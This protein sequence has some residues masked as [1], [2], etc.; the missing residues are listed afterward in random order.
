MIPLRPFG[1]TGLKVP[2]IS[3]GG[4]ALSGEGGGYGF[5]SISE[6]EALDLLARALDGGITLFD[7]APVYGFGL[8]EKRIGKAFS[9]LR[10]RVILASKAGITWSDNK[11]IHLDCRP[12][13]VETMLAQSLKHLATDYIDI[14][15]IHA[16]DPKVDIRR[17]MQ[18]L[19][20]AKRRGRIGCIGLCNVSARDILKAAEVD[21]VDVVQNEFNLFRC[22]AAAEVFPVTEERTIAFMSWG[23]LDKGILT[24][25]VTEQRGFEKT[26]VRCWAPWLKKKY[27]APRMEAMAKISGVLEA[28][29]HSGL[30]LALGFVLQHPQVATALCG[31]RNRQQLESCLLA[32]NH[33]PSQEIL[34]ACR[35]IAAE[36]SCPDE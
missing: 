14:Y 28:H 24:G 8:S 5:G 32:L 34:S 11:R 16:P 17:T 25:R 35:Q 22:S 20:E 26:D 2:V 6:P 7:T 4:A 1:Q 19:A 18:V 15:L 27:K 23:T 29:S 21:R 30:E 3:F 12:E 33:L 9:K 31:I 10:E 36:K 13:T